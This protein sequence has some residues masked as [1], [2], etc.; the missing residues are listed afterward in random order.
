MRNSVDWTAP[1]TPRPRNGVQRL[2]TSEARSETLN[3]ESTRQCSGPNHTSVSSV[4]LAISYLSATAA[5]ICHRFECSGFRICRLTDVLP[6]HSSS[7]TFFCSSG[8]SFNLKYPS[9]RPPLVKIPSGSYLRCNRLSSF[10]LS[11][12]SPVHTSWKCSA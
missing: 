2:T 6:S 10:R 11:S 9:A 1:T 7:F 12:P 4:S 3:V 8:F 5:S